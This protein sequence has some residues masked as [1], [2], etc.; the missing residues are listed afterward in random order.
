VPARVPTHNPFGVQSLARARREY[1]RNRRDPR[2]KAFYDSAAWGRVR[3]HK[4]RCNPLCEVC[5]RGGL[6][7]AAS[8]V[9]HVTPLADCP[10]LAFD[11]DNLES[12]CGP[13]HSR[14]HASD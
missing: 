3:R 7:V 4:L 11:W 14:H 5:Q 10:D 6:I 13:C 12:I 2:A 8:I 1:D 9:H